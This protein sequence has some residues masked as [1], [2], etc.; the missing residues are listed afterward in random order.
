MKLLTKLFPKKDSFLVFGGEAYYASGGAKD[1]LLTTNN[2]IEAL[3][4][5]E[6]A[7]G[8]TRTDEPQE[9]KWRYAQTVEI[10]W[11]QVYSLPKDSIIMRY[12]EEP[13]GYEGTI[14]RT[15]K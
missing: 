5:A 8:K 11:T 13:L 1:L 9:C 15:L 6:Q 14:A 7:I 12:G 3:K 10:E 4:F 2:L